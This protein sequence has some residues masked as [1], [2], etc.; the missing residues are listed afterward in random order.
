MSHELLYTSAPKGLKAG[1]RGFCTV[2]CTQGMP[3]PLMT[4]LES[5]SAYRHIY[6]PGDRNASK[7]PVAWSHLKMSVAGRAYHVLSRIADFGLDYSQ[8]GNKLAH[9]VAF[10]PA[11][12]TAGGPAWLLQQSGNMATDWNGHPRLLPAGRQ[13]RSVPRPPAVCTAWQAMTGDAGWAGVLAESFLANP[14]RQVYIVF[15]PGMD[16]LP[17]LAEAIALLPAERRWDVTFS[18]YFTSLPPGVSCAWRCVLSGSPEAEQARKFGKALHIDLCQPV[19]PAVGGSLVQAALNGPRHATRD[20]WAASRRPA[21]T[22]RECEPEG[23]WGA[24]PRGQKTWHAGI[25]R[26]S[27][28][29]GICD[30]RRRSRIWR[31]SP[32][33]DAA[34]AAAS[35]LQ[36][37]DIG[38]PERGRRRAG[39]NGIYRSSAAWSVLMLVLAVAVFA[40]PAAREWVLPRTSPSKSPDDAHGRQCQPRIAQAGTKSRG[41]AEEH[42]DASDS[43]DRD[44]VGATKG[45][46]DG[47]DEIQAIKQ[48]ARPTAATSQALTAVANTDE[49]TGANKAC[50]RTIVRHDWRDANG[51]QARRRAKAGF[52]RHRTLHGSANMT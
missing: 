17:L 19:P 38:R 5:L 31:R 29:S 23:E 33:W 9:H 16:L 10:E 1:S 7:N 44:E 13:L 46:R 3:A 2:V 47:A 35:R 25:R 42:D 32:R 18:T 30:T 34:P 51:D 27:G 49:K 4:A 6:P 8:R 36:S 37:A 14:G 28:I 43:E 41:R 40:V 50:R 21:P 26:R 22:R 15:E 39:G 48:G 45:G 20:N 52:V 12:Q 11:E 24:A